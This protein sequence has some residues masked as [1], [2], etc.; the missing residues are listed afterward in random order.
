MIDEPQHPTLL[1]VADLPERK[2][3]RFSLK[4]DAETCQEIAT[5][6]DL[7]ALRKV[8]FAGTVKAEGRQNWQLEGILGA[9]VVQPCVVTLAPVTTRID[10]PVVRHF[11]KDWSV[12]IESDEV[13]MPEDDSTEPLTAEIDLLA[14]LIEALALAIPD[15][16]R[17]NEARLKQSNFAAE[18]VTPMTDEDT[19]PFAS[20]SA[21]KNKLEEP[22]A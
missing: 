8:S 22:D 6:L 3:Y 7:T 17:A 4:P 9:T 18:G 20:L 21:L 15:Y 11:V 19:K 16:P 2:P 12:P 14:V 13:E 10:V 5:G 1:R